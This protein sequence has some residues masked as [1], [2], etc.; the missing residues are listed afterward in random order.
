MSWTNKYCVI[1]FLI[2]DTFFKVRITGKNKI[3]GKKDEVSVE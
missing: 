3:K 2:M 1:L